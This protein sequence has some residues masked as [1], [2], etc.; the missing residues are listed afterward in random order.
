M[1]S[2]FLD[3]YGH[4]LLLAGIVL[5]ALF[6]RVY[7]L[8]WDRGTYLH[9]DERFIA[10][11]SAN[12]ISFP[13]DDPGAIFDPAN[14]PLNPR[15]DNAD[16][17]PESFAYGTLPLYVQGVASW[18]LNAFSER[19]W[20]RYED[21]YYV[22]RLLSALVDMA[23]LAFV[24]LLTRRLFGRNAALLA[25]ALYGFAVLPIQLTHF[26]TVDVWLTCFVTAA[27]FFIIRYV[28]QPSLSRAL[29]VGAPV[30]LAFATKAS[31]PTLAALAVAAFAW[32]LYK[33]RPRLAVVEHALAAGLVSLATFTL[34]EPYALVRLDA[35]MHDISTQSR[36]VRG[37]FDVPFTRQFVGLTPGVYELDNLFRYTLGPAFVLCALVAVVWSARVATRERSVALAVPLL[38]IAGYVPVLLYTEARFLRYALPLVPVLAVLC[39]GLLARA[40]A[41]QRPAY[42]PRIAVACVLLVTAL[43]GIGFASIYARENPRLAVS[44]WMYA[45]IPPDAVVSAES[46]DDPLPLRLGPGSP[47]FETVWLDIYGDLPPAE[48]VDQLWESLQTVDY[49]VLSSDRVRG[50][51]DNLPWRYAVQNEFYHRLD[52]GQLGYQLVYEAALQ[53][54]LFGVRYDD[55]GADESFWVYD[56]PTVRIYQR[57]EPLT[58]DEFRARFA[59]SLAQPWEPQR[60]AGRNSLMLDQPVA[61]TPVSQ[62]AG[63]NG[64]AVSSGAFAALVWLLAVEVVGLA[65]LPL[66]ARIFAGRLPVAVLSTRLIGLLL[67]GW[68]VWIG[69]ALQL[70][71]ARS[72]VIGLMVCLMAGSAWGWRAL[73]AGKAGWPLPSARVYGAAS[74]V[75]VGI[76]VCFLALRAIYPDFWQTYLGGEKP[77]ELAYLRAIAASTEYPPYDPWFS[78]GVINYYYYGWHL[79]ATLIKLTGVG[80]THGFQLGSATAAALLGS[81]VVGLALLLTPAGHK[82]RR[83]V[84]AVGTAALALVA[85]LIA[86]N[87]DA[88]RQVRELGSALDR[89]DFWGPTRVIDGT[90]NEFPFFSQLWA[91][92]HPHVLSMPMFALLA[93]LMVQLARTA[94]ARRRLTRATWEDIALPLAIA[95]VAVGGIAVTNAW[96]AP[97]SIAVLLAGSAY[98]GL[99]AGLVA[100]LL[101][102]AAGALAAAVGLLLF[103]PF[104]LRFYSVTEGI[105]IVDFPSQLGQWLT[106]W[107][108]FT[109]I[110]STAIVFEFNRAMRRRRWSPDGWYAATLVLGVAGLTALLSGWRD[111]GQLWAFAVAVVWAT[112]AVVLAAVV[113]EPSRRMLLWAPPLVAL[114]G[115]GAALLPDRPA[116]GLALC[117]VAATGMLALHN[118]WSPRRFYPWA[119]VAVAYAVIG[120]T[121]L[122]FVVD[123]LNGGPW[124]RMNT[125]FKFYLPA[126]ILLGAGSAVLLARMWSALP[127]DWR[128]FTGRELGAIAS[129]GSALTTGRAERAGSLRIA[130]NFALVGI[131]TAALALGLVYPVVGTPVRLQQDMPTSP[132][133]LTLDGYAW[134]EHGWILNGTGERI[135]FGGDLDAIEWLNDHADG[136][137]VILE[138]AI[139][140]YRGNGARISSGTGLPTVLGWDRH[141]TQQRYSEDIAVR[142]ADVHTL[143]N[144]TDLAQKLSLLRRYGV[145]FVVVGDV[146]RRWNTP[147]QPRPYASE[148][149]L[150]AFDQLVGSGLEVVFES[151]ATRIYEVVDFPRLPP[152]PGAVHN[153]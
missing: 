36:I 47:S 72:W 41:L 52:E 50:S 69:A 78:D 82:R 54:E 14:S 140:P 64:W 23:T 89:F 79:V 13:F 71:P 7:G 1:A 32:A 98:A 10:M 151:G 106:F 59:W 153:L 5:A 102:T 126:W 26:F 129:R 46:W 58:L 65:A 56:H 113:T 18:A 15:R 86:G 68:L 114:A 70:W 88:V 103:A 34:F 120:A 132:T 76:F 90:I 75:F 145:R 147:E 77:F 112:A 109:I 108:I 9:P 49:V 93:T 149:G 42:L 146:E 92:L 135:E 28:D 25:A 94:H 111:S 66:S 45:N 134:M 44:E 24:Y 117:F 22:G 17:N 85:V 43:W 60:Y 53:P 20:G 8:D 27:L 100:S 115:I 12:R 128:G 83:L 121:E 133:W 107:G 143:Y 62:D 104:F 105:G 84:R 144:S 87:L 81:Q 80:V 99:R 122:V 40:L 136:A 63:W 91:D 125:V 137:E 3:R 131:S 55:S 130:L 57:V 67:V 6:L 74:A 138:G 29:A 51:V 116:G 19:D 16:D 37:I 39:G 35:F 110:V 118:R 123:D 95:G 31:V 30:G 141:Q 48:K 38:W 150:Q 142:V 127:L 101:L 148:A 152:A 73:R 11:V 97:L 33:S 61:E 4:R 2:S 119:L 124:Q 21:L 139:G 96:D